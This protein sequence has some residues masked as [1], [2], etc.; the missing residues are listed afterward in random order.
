[1]V[2]ER[3]SLGT[4]FDSQNPFFLD[5]LCFLL[6]ARD[7]S[8]RSVF[9]LLPLQLNPAIMDSWLSGTVNAN[10]LFSSVSR[11]SHGV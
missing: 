11:L 10:K 6:A 1:M 8:P 3:V 5:S 4:S 2:E 9:L 7:A